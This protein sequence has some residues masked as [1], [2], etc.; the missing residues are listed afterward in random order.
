MAVRPSSSSPAPSAI[1]ALVPQGPHTGKPSMPMGRIF[2]MVGSRHRAH[3]HLLSRSVSKAH[4]AIINDHGNI[5]IRDTAS[6]EQV[7]VNGQP[8][9]EVDL[10]NG[11]M[12]KIGSFVFQLLDKSRTSGRGST[13]RATEAAVEFEPGSL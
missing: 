7:L 8:V 4:A 2:T 9:K 5:Y 10:R 13:R 11:D 1:P 3:L 6:R 12:I